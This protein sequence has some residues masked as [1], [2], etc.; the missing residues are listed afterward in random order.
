SSVVLADAGSTPAISTKIQF[1]DVQL[2]VKKPLNSMFKGFFI[3]STV[4]PHPKLF[5]PNFA[6]IG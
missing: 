6:L 4:R 1:R 5:D 2:N 3:G